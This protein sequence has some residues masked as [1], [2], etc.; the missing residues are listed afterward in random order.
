MVNQQVDRRVISMWRVQAVI[1]SLLF[2]APLATGVGYW[3]AMNGAFLLGVVLGVALFLVRLTLSLVW[4]ALIWSHFSYSLRENDLTVKRGV[5]FRR[6]STIPYSRI[7]HV[8]T[9]QGP[10][11]QLFG[12]GQLHLFT[13]SG[14]SADGSIPGFDFELAEQLRDVLADKAGLDRGSEGSGDGV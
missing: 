14:M 10:L 5:L 8:D 13:A 11:E 12:L 1:V 3:V 7:Q 9:H 4:P 2:W 6:I